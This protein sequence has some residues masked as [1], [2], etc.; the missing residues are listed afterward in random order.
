[1]RAMLVLSLAVV[2]FL[3]SAC[4]SSGDGGARPPTGAEEVVVIPAMGE[5]VVGTQR[6]TFAVFTPEGE[7]VE[8]G[9]ASVQFV[10]LQGRQDVPK[11]RV[12]ASY[13]RVEVETPH[14]HEGGEVHGH[15]DVKAFFLVR[16]GTFDSP[17][18]W[19]ADVTLE[20][21]K[22]AGKKGSLAFEVKEGSTTPAVGA[23]AP[24]TRNATAR[25][26]RDLAEL[27]SRTPPYAAFHQMSVAE[28]LEG[29]RPFVVAFATPAFCVSRICGPVLEIVRS[30][31]DEVGDKAVFIQIEPYDLKAARTQGR[32]ELVPAAREWG[33]QSE[34]WVFVVDGRGRVAAK[35]EGLL[36]PQ[37]LL[38]A[39][40][41]VAG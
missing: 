20:G 35:F 24:A 28:A 11:Q 19:R 39:I 34:P 7:A 30:V 10:L 41:Q 17:G 14:V 23:T 4:S 36:T 2:A 13:Y 3:L 25:D 1:M 26:V 21:G 18:F 16:A 12:G 33:L 9:G 40:K 27:T 6:F 22:A 31:A 5:T 37:E 8:A 32:L 38:D 29:R 15:E